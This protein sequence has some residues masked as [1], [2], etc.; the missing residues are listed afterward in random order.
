MKKTLLSLA[1]V[2]ALSGHCIEYNSKEN[3]THLQK[4]IELNFKQ[5]EKILISPIGE[6]VGF[7]GRVFKIDGEAVIANTKANAVDLPFEINHGFDV[8]YGGKAA[9]WIDFNSLE[10]RKDGIYGSLEINDL[11]KEL[12]DGKFYRYVSPAFIM[13]RNKEDRSVLSLDS[14]GLVNAPNLVNKAL[15]SKADE[16]VIRELNTKITTLETEKGQ[17]VE[18]AEG[19][20]KELEETNSKLTKAEENY[21]KIQADLKTEKEVNKSLRIDL[22]VEQNKILPKDREFCKSLDDAQLNSYIQNNA[23]SNLAKELGLS[24]KPNEQNSNKSRIEIAAKAGS[25]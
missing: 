8:L 22:A 9:G 15:N 19:T 7:D 16:S 25:K 18:T 17:A 4:A 20:A 11:G 2:A 6:V 13:D 24:I 12:I 5:G 3:S 14:V 23:G 21:K 1:T 10:L